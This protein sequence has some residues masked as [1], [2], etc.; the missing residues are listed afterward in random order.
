MQP[1]RY[2]PQSPG[3][4][5]GHFPRSII[6]LPSKRLTPSSPGCHCKSCGQLSGI[7]ILSRFC[8]DREFKL[9]PVPKGLWFSPSRGELREVISPLTDI[10][11]SNLLEV[12]EQL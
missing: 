2:F 1:G 7:S 11:Q 12:F 9:S 4:P 6:S 5:Y 3:A 8:E 10:L